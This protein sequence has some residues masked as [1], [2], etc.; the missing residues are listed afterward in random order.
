MCSSRTFW[1]ALV[2]IFARSFLCGICDAQANGLQLRGDKDSPFA[3]VNE[4]LFRAADSTL[5]RS[6]G[7]DSVAAVGSD[8]HA[9]FKPAE[10]EFGGSVPRSETLIE[11]ILAREG[12]PVELSAVVKVESSGN[13][14]ALSQK[15]ARGLWQ[16]MPDT[17][18]RYG[19]QVDAR[20]DE[21]T[22]V[23]KS[24]TAA[25]RY[26]HDLYSQFGSWPLAL[27]AYNTGESNLQRAIYRAQS[28]QFAV[29]SFLRVIPTETR[30]YVPA[31]LAKIALPFAPSQS[32]AAEST[33]ANLVYAGSDSP[34]VPFRE[35]GR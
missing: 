31:V 9:A 16:L 35:S 6:L 11:S 26:L 33:P 1:C 10:T 18:R 29:L 7:T 15:G 25:A 4:S 21:R 19:L 27:A 3:S 24:T 20:R 30:S 2:M 5:G 32:H 23:E 17:A 8:D 13:R 34:E 22:D 12:V 14:F 28:N